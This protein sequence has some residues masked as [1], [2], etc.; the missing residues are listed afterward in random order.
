MRAALR[1]SKIRAL[2]EEKSMKKL[3]LTSPSS[4]TRAT[5]TLWPA[6][7]AAQGDRAV[8]FRAVQNCKAAGPHRKPN[9]ALR[10]QEKIAIKARVE[11]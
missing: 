11:A 6:R 7:K 3:K 1:A 2:K 8:L 5:F 10:R 4:V 9:K